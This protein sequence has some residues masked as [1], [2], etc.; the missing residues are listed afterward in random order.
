MR[1][2]A[3]PL[4]ESSAY[5]LAFA[6][7]PVAEP[8]E[9]EPADGGEGAST[10]VTD[11]GEGDGPEEDDASPDGPAARVGAWPRATRLSDE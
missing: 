11:E 4:S 2:I 8:S 5:P 9:A 3:H 1:A 7:D 6:S 10:D